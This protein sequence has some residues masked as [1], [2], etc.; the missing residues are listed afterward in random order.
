MNNINPIISVIVP[1]YNAEKYLRRCINSILAQTFTDFELLLIDD[2]ST[3]QSG[4][5]CDE[6]ADKDARIKV[7]HKANGGV[8]SARNVGLDNAVGEY[9]CFCDADDWVDRTWLENF[10]DKLPCDMVVQGYKYKSFNTGKW[11]SR[12]LPN[13]CLPVNTALKLLFEHDNM[14]YLWC[15]CFRASLIKKYNIRFNEFFILGEDYDFILS[16]CLHVKEI[17]LVEVTSYNY[18]EPNCCLKYKKESILQTL[19]CVISKL[20]KLQLIFSKDMANSIVRV[21][22]LQLQS[23]LFRAFIHKKKIDGANIL[24]YQK[25]KK[26]NRYT[27][28]NIK[29]F[30]K[31]KCIIYGYFLKSNKF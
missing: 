23:S 13:V 16:F 15:R 18:Y 2:G 31:D 19:S 24:A 22:V 4:E 17:D 1:A 12:K 20:Q 28:S 9:I 3:D 10:C 11:K 21:E 25:Y 14:G 30:M 27:P 8:S 26:N 5:I 29:E 7:F 6:Y